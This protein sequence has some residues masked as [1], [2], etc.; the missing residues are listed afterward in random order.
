MSYA[1]Q[2]T[3]KQRQLIVNTFQFHQLQINI[4]VEECEHT[5]KV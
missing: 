1:E 5:C 4:Q 2:K 3:Y